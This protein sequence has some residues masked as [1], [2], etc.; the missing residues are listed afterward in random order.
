M[1]TGMRTADHKANTNV[2]TVER[3]FT[4]LTT[5]NI[6]NA[7]ELISPLYLDHE[8][9]VADIARSLGGA[10]QFRESIRWL[11]RVFADVEFEEQELIAAD[12]R[13]VVRGVM[14]GRHVGRLLDIAPKGKRVEVHQVH[15]FRLAG[16]KVVEHRA[17]WGELSL[18]AQLMSEQPGH[19]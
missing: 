10:A 8:A 7:D 12:D 9:P 5:G 3:V 18:L 17:L 15:I 11:H 14:R 6:V 13:V 19:R 2:R 16:G 4:A 1:G